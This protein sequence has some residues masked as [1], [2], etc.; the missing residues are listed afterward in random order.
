VIPAAITSPDRAERRH[1]SLGERHERAD[2]HE[3]GSRFPLED[4]GDRLCCV[5]FVAAGVAGYVAFVA[6]VV[7]MPA[8]R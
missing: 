3:G 6:Y 5:A 4:L 7:S 2:R 8:L 1:G